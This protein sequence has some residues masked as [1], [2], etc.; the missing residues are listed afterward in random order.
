M[1]TV[2][3]QTYYNP[4][5]LSLLVF[6]IQI[7]MMNTLTPEVKDEGYCYNAR[8]ELLLNRSLQNTAWNHLCPVWKKCTES[9]MSDNL[10]ETDMFCGGW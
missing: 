9:Q 7:Q 8:P 1:V 10:L 2:V 3:M 5:I 4:R 6:G